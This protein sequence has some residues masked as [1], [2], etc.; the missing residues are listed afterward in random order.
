MKDTVNIPRCSLSNWKDLYDAAVSFADIKCWEWMSDTDVFGVQNPEIGEIGYCCV[1]GEMGEVYGLV[2]YLVSLGLEQHHKI[3]SKRLHA[4]SPDF[5]Y[6]QS[7]LTAW[8]GNR[9]DLDDT[10]RK[11]VKELGL[12]FRGSDASPQFRSMQPGYFPWYLSES[13]AKFLILCL[14]QA[15]QVALD[16]KNNPD[17]LNAPAKNLYFVRIPSKMA[18]DSVSDSPA[19][20]LSPGRQQSLFPVAGETRVRQWETRWL[21]PAPLVKAGVKPFP[22]DELRLQ[23][24]KKSSQSYNGAWEVDAFFTTQPVA[25]DDRPF[26]PYT[27]LCADHDSGFIWSTVL[28]EPSTWETE[29]PKSFLQGVEEHKLLPA[30]LSFRKEQLRELFT[31]LATQLGIEV[32]ITKKLP[33]V[34]RAKRELLKFIGKKL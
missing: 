10:D 22:L 31:P 1:L 17:C 13:E 20:G 28:A 16:F 27:L 12:K 30:T 6:S 19:S 8:F 23:R 34:D 11:I 29:F 4:G 9:R 14:E 33:A 32:E 26:F 18:D 7:C 2:V 25:G 3:Q 21:S 15:R 5:A 24:I